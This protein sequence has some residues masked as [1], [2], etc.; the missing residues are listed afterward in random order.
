MG[1]VATRKCAC[2]KNAINI[3]KNNVK[4]VLQFQNKYYHSECFKN[5]ATEKAASKRSKPQVWKD[6]LERMWELETETKNVLEYTFARD[7]L[8]FW[9]LEN[10]NITTTPSWFWT[11]VADL[12]NG[13]YKGKRCKPVPIRT[14]C[15]CWKWGQQKLN[16][17]NQNNKSHNKGPAS[18]N[19]RLRYDLAILVLRVP[20]FLAYK[21]KQK[22]AEI[23]RQREMK[24]NIK[25]DYSKIV[26]NTI[27]NNNLQ[28]I[29]SLVD[30]IF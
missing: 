7:E 10:Y 1:D 30:D 26:N 20:Q 16:E 8:H 22:A 27:Q 2:C 17:I 4:D 24:E 12:H 21:E 14:L 11:I 28:D 9:L 29:S 13:I 18:D 23:E 3:D 15:E 6:A 5:M 19:E 25:V